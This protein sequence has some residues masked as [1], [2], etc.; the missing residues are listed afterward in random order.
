M[1]YGLIGETLGHSYSKEI[2]EQLA[3][4]TYDLMPVAS[5]DFPAFMKHRKFQAINVTIPYKEQV[6]PYLAGM[7][8]RSKAIHAVNTIVNQN[9]KLYG[10]NT[11]FDGFLYTLKRHQIDV[12]RKKV[13]V[14]GYGGASKAVLAVL[15]Y[16]K[17]GTI[18][19]VNRTPY[20]A[21][22]SYEE[23]YRTCTD[24]D[25]IINTTSVGMYP[26][27]ESSPLDL[28]N[29]QKCEAVIDIIYNPLKTKLLIE[30]KQLG[31]KAVN[32]LEMLV[33][34]AKYAVEHFQNQKID[35]SRIDDI[36]QS[37]HQRVR[38]LVLIG[39]PSVGKTTIGRQLSRIMQRPF[40]DLDQKLVETVNMSIPD[41]FQAHGETAFRDREIE[42]CR[43][44][45]V[46]N[47]L[48]IATGGGA[49]L[50]YEN[51]QALQS[52]GLIIWLRRPLSELI[53]DETRPLSSSPQAIKKLYQERLPLYEKAADLIIDNDQSLDHTIQQILQSLINGNL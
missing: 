53:S 44:Y 34:Q 52:N 21:T 26:K 32:G 46:Q 31:I 3:D 13:I 23:C 45:G 47:N 19:I 5:A 38:N 27:I 4:Y 9:G 48:I 11:D 37:L 2:H 33:A 51:I 20:T 30:A 14:L 40:V 16:L 18:I 49:V 25:I 22:I 39:M 35:N 29:F 41:Y 50:R 12:A 1:K 17:A 7:D 10:F 36:Y 28:H 8:E 42:V 43:Q 24:A 15:K 6:I